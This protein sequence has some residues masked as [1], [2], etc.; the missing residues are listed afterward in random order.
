MY[1]EPPTFLLVFCLL[2]LLACIIAV[3]FALFVKKYPEVQNWIRRYSSTKGPE[4]YIFLMFI[5][6]AFSLF[7]YFIIATYFPE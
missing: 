2:L 1:Q 5:L 3:L 4:K 6:F 7:I